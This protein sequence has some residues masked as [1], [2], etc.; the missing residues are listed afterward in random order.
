MFTEL[1]EDRNKILIVDDTP[2]NIDILGEIL[3]DY[4]KFIAT[5]GER[6]LK[7]A[8]E[9]LPDLILLDIMMPGMDG[10]EVCKRLKSDNDTKDIPVIFITAKNQVEDEVK[11]LEIGAVDFIAKPISPPIVQAR[12]KAHLDLKMS[13]EVLELRNYELSSALTEL[14]ETQHQLIH[15]EKMAALGQLVAGIAHEINTPLGAINSSNTSIS[16]D[17]DFLFYKAPHIYRNIDDEL[18]NI[19]FE[20]LKKSDERDY[21][22]SSR[23]ERQYKRKIQAILE[24]KNIQNYENLAEI[25][26]SLRIYEDIE[27]FIKLIESDDSEKILHLASLLT[28]IKFSNKIIAT[29]IDRVSKIVFSL[30]NFARF[31]LEGKR[32]L[33]DI[34]ENIET[35]LTLYQ[36]QLKHGV[37]LVKNFKLDKL[38][39]FVPDQLIQ[40]WTNLIHNALQAMDH[41]GTLTISTEK[42]NDF[43]KITIS[44]TGKGIPNDI[45]KKIFEPFFTTKPPGEGTGLGL[46]IV[47]K[48]IKNHN[49]SIDVKSEVGVGTKFIIYLPI[50]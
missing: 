1:T 14:K 29:A 11:G 45:I 27:P 10:F 37:E 32:I 15:S 39:D 7:L 26:V 25:L 49:G 42:Y 22:L 47:N 33:G 43:A 23:E 41:K 3:S 20:L 6:A 34:N 9:K 46:D 4:K 8:K 21:Y 5:N 38:L 36:N 31:D 35:V 18:L 50:L 17:L 24:E 44:D 13:K 28:G 16:K 30:K 19:F 12:V 40:V 2:E 48:I